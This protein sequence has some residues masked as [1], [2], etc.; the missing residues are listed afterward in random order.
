M[1]PMD[2]FKENMASTLFGR[3]RELAR[4]GR[5]CVCCGGPATK[6]RDELSRREYS[7]SFLCQKCQDEIWLDPAM[8]EADKS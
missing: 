8:D 1:N 7:I 6:F 5:S 2:S 4:A 3:S